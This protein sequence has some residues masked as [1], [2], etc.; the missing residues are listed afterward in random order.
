MQWEW[1]HSPDR[2]R[3]LQLDYLECGWP[4]RSVWH[5]TWVVDEEVALQ[6]LPVSTTTVRTPHIA[7]PNGLARQASVSHLPICIRAWPFLVNTLVY[8]GVLGSMCLL[9]GWFRRTRRRRRGLCAVCA[10]PVGP[11][12]ACSECG[13]TRRA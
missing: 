2:Y 8:A 11:T 12:A 10:Y 9:P 4:L 1:I 3:V 7:L 5:R 6:G 13:A